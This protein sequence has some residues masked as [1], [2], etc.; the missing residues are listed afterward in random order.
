MIPGN[1]EWL[2]YHVFH[3]ILTTYGIPYK[4]FTDRRTVFT[5]KKKNSPSIDEDTYTQF[6][7]ACKTAGG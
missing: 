3:Q 4:F 5:Y 7:Y 1:S 2:D 6:A